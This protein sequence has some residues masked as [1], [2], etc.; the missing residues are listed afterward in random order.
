MDQGCPNEGKDTRLFGRVTCW[1]QRLGTFK[2]SLPPPFVRLEFAGV[3]VI[4]PQVRAQQKV[5]A[6]ADWNSD[7]HAR[8]YIFFSGMLKRVSASELEP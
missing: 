4:A 3:V 8:E 7:P 5:P 2:A 1:L 6:G